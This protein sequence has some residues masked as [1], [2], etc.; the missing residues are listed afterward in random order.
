[1]KLS[2]SK[3]KDANYEEIF[4]VRKLFFLQLLSRHKREKLTYPRCTAPANSP[5][6]THQY[7][8]PE[9]QGKQ[10]HPHIC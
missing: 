10:T 5:H 4:T 2:L 6:H 1:M 9:T 7:S 3:E 8:A